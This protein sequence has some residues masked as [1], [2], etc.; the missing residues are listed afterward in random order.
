VEALD[1]EA[2]GPADIAVGTIWFTVPVALEVPGAIA[3]HLCQCYEGIYEGLEERWREID[4]VYRLPTR[5]LAVSRHLAEILERRFGQTVTAIPQPFRP[6]LFH[7]PSS[8]PSRADGFRLLLTGRFDL[9]VKGVAWAMGE[10]LPLLDESPRLELVRIS[11]EMD[12]EELRAWPSAERHVSLHPDR[13]PDVIR[14]VHAYLGP[15]ME[16]EGFG[17]PALEAMGCG[18]PCILSDIAASRAL[19]SRSRASLRI[20]SGQGQALR[21]AVRALRDDPARCRRLGRAGRRIAAR[22]TEERTAKALRKAFTRALRQR[23]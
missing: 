3:F 22:Y 1:G 14:S 19:D 18:R 9:D 15:S 2:I 17:L 6:D 7:P 13:V 8:E 11:Q 12:D 4:E 16:A 23:R 10:L 20:P 21:E 5:K